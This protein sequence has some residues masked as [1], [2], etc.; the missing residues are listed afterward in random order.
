MSIEYP[1]LDTPTAGAIRFNTD[2]SHLEIYDGNQWVNALASSPEL[3]T[4]GTRGL[5]WNGYEGS[6]NI[7]KIEYINVDT[8]GNATDFGDSTVTARQRGSLASRSRSLGFGGYADPGAN[9]DTIDYITIASTGNSS[10]FGNLSAATSEMPRGI[11]NSTR[12][13]IAGGQ[14]PG[15]TDTIE[16]VTIATTGNAADFGNL[17]VSR[18]GMAGNGGSPTRGVFGGGNPNT[19][20]ID[21]ITISTLG[22]AADFG[23]LTQARR[24][25]SCGQ[26]SNAVRCIFFGGQTPTIVTTTDYITIASLGNALDFGDI[27]STSCQIGGCASPTRA[28]WAGGYSPG[29]QIEYVQIMTTGNATD[30][31]DLGAARQQPA[32]SSNGHG[33]L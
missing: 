24:N 11:S 6:S 18:G 23:D 13:I 27:G 4:G 17:T 12:G 33:G 30:Y 5:W 21:Y 8:T 10:D 25:G 9:T 1:S 28:V 31:G 19:N 15:S 2:S 22:N 32:G 3:R 16:Y 29:S 7:N 20:V 26:T 14:S